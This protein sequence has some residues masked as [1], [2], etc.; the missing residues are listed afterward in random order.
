[1]IASAV[2]QIHRREAFERNVSR[3]MVA[4]AAAGS[5]ELVLEQIAISV[6]L[7]APGGQRLM[8]LAYLSIAAAAV[9]CVR[10]DRM[11]RILLFAFSAVLPA[12]PWLMGL[13]ASWALGASAAIAGA[14]M[15]R[16]HLCERGE[17]GQVAEG[18]PGLPNYLFGAALCALLT[19]A[20]TQVARV[21]ATRL[22]QLAAPAIAIALVSG[23]VIALFAALASISA[24]LGLLPDPVEARCEEVIAQLSG[25]FQALTS[26]A[27][28]LYRQCGRSLALLPRELAREELARTLAA[29]TRD[30]AELASHWAGVEAQLALGAEQELSSEAADLERSAQSAQDAIARRQLELAARSLREEAGSV[31]V[32]QVRRERIVARVKAQVALLE[33]ARVAL[34]GLRSGRAQLKAA[35]LAVVSRK[36]T[37]LSVLQSDAARMAD[38]VA[39]AT[40]EPATSDCDSFDSR[41][42]SQALP[43]P[44]RV[45]P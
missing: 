15:V 5:L 27:L 43:A 32:L 1:V 40:M 29:T 13:A 6:G 33:R 23:T 4:G 31:H 20:G 9:A 11:D 28:E 41:D 14:L 8:F 3:A 21:L 10:G 34:I 2:I 44:L 45:A 26:R 12:A 35:E 16:S 19:L 24:H 37:A 18:R 7:L 30:T 17:E 25:E 36:L 22:L 38:E 42:A 39:A